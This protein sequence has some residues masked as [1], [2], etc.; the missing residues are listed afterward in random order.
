MFY[1]TVDDSNDLNFTIYNTTEGN[2]GPF[3]D[4]TDAQLKDRIFNSRSMSLNFNIR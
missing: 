4:I 1:F 3:E 2:L